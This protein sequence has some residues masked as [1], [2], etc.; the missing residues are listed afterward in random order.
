MALL[1]SPDPE[2]SARFT[3]VHVTSLVPLSEYRQRSAA[4][5][6]EGSKRNKGLQH[7]HGAQEPVAELA[8]ASA[9][10]PSLPAGLLTAL[11]RLQTDPTNSSPTDPATDTS[12]PEP[13]SSADTA[14]SETATSETA[15]SETATSAPSTTEPPTTSDTSDVGVLSPSVSLVVPPA[16]QQENF[17]AYIDEV[18]KRAEAQEVCGANHDSCT[19]EVRKPVVLYLLVANSVDPNG[20]PVAPD[21]AAER[22]V[23]VLKDGRRTEGE[24]PQNSQPQGEPLGVVVSADLEL[25]GLR[26]KPVM[27]SWSMWQQ[28]GKKRLYGNWL[29]RNLAYRLEATTDHDTTTLHLWIPLPKSPGPYFIRVTLTAAGSSLAG[30]NSPPFD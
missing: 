29:N 2:D 27:L 5:V 22:V 11:G 3:A 12:A 26:G 8:L 1:P 15:T 23:K 30:S 16:L 20:N 21:V 28:G 25:V 9:N 17:G 18:R 19:D 10:K 6:P 13:S 14:T 4:M 24:Q 7:D